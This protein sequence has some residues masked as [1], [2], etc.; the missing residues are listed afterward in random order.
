LKNESFGDRAT[1][2]LSTIGE[3]LDK[4]CGPPSEKD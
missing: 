4:I 3:N 1:A 2:E